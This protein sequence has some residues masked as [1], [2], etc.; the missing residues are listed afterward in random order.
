MQHDLAFLHTA[1]AHVETFT[2]ITEEVSPG[3]RVRHVVAEGLLEQARKDG[4]TEN[5]RQHVR[6]AV[7]EAAS[8]GACVVVCTCSTIGGLAEATA[9]DFRAMRIDRAMA[10]FAV[11]QGRRILV[12]AALESTLEPTLDLLRDSARAC[13]AE[14]QMTALLA[15]NAWAYFEQ[16]DRQSYTDAIAT[17]ILANRDGFDAVVLAQASMAPAAERCGDIGIP[18]LSSPRMGVEAAVRAVFA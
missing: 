7:A 12:A 4:L 11:R 18:V 13:G 6:A 5:L 10:D 15:E 17:A 3:L 2:R 14:V 9:G 8:S 1:E 16:G